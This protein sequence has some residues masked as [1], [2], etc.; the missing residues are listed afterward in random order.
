MVPYERL[1]AAS[2]AAAWGAVGRT[3]LLLAALF[4]GLPFVLEPAWRRLSGG[5]AP[6]AGS[7]AFLLV[8]FALAFCVAGVVALGAS[9]TYGRAGA[10]LGAEARR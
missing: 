2:H 10:P 4:A 6:A 3:C 1:P 9:R 8:A 7:A 5:D